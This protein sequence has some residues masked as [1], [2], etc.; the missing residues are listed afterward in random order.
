MNVK[1]YLVSLYGLIFFNVFQKRTIFIDQV[2][3]EYAGKITTKEEEERRKQIV[4]KRGW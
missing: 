4:R 1:I 3:G 2:K